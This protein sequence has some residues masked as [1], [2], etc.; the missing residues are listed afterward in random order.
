MQTQNIYESNMYDKQFEPK[1][2]TPVKQ[3]FKLEQKTIDEIQSMKPKFGFNGLGE[4]VFRRTYSRDNETWNDVVIRVIEGVMSIRKDH[5]CK[6]SLYWSDKEWQPFAREI[7]ISMFNMEWLPPGRGL[8]M[9][10]TDFAYKRGSMALNNCFS[11]DTQFWT[12]EGL[13]SFGDYKDG[14]KVTVRGKNKWMP[15]TIRSFGVQKLWELK[16]QCKGKTNTIFTTADHRWIVEDSIKTTKELENG[17]KLFTIEVNNKK[18]LWE[19]SSVTET[20]RTEEVWCVVE[21]EYEEFTLEGGIVTKNCAATETLYDLVHSAEWTMDAL[22]NGVGCGFDTSWRGSVSRPNKEDTELFVIDDSR[23]G[24]VHSLIK[25]MCAY[26]DS[27]K[28]GKNKFPKFDYSLIREAGKPIKGFGGLASGPAPLQKLHKRVESYLDSFCN[29][30]IENKDKTEKKPYNHTR[31]IADIFNAIGACVVAGNVRRCLPEGSRVHTN[32]GLVPIEEVK[33]GDNVCTMKGYKKV[34]NTFDQ[35]KQKLVKINTNTGHFRCTPNHRM[36]VHTKYFDYEWKCASELKSGDRLITSH[37]IIDGEKTQL[38]EQKNLTVPKLDKELAWFVGFWQNQGTNLPSSLVTTCCWGSKVKLCAQFKRFNV[39]I[40]C[41]KDYGGEAYNNNHTNDSY[42]VSCLDK[43]VVSYFNKHIKCRNVDKIPEYIMRGT[44]EVRQGYIFGITEN[45]CD[46]KFLN[47]NFVNDLQ[48]L[49]YSCGMST[50]VNMEGLL[51]K[52]TFMVDGIR[53]FTQN[54]YN[55]SEVVKVVD[56]ET[57]NTYD[58]EVEE[59]HEFFCNGY[60]TH[61]SAEIALGDV[62]DKTFINLKNYGLNPERG[63]IGWMSNNSVV[64]QPYDDYEDFSYIPEMAKRIHD[65]GEPGMIN[66]Y[67]MQKFGRYGKEMKDKANLVNPCVTDDTWVTTK[68]GA[69]QVKDLIGKKF[70]AMVDGKLYQCNKGFFSTGKKAVFK[71]VT[72]EGFE[73]RA[74]AN[75]KIMTADNEWV[76][77]KDLIEGDKVRV[78][79]HSVVSMIENNKE[80]SKGWLIGSLYGDGVVYHNREYASLSYKGETAQEM[81]QIAT[82]YLNEHKMDHVCGN[83]SKQYDQ[84]QLNSKG[85]FTL[86][87]Q[88]IS[89][90]R[91]LTN[92]IEKQDRA[93]IQGFLRGWFDTNSFIQEDKKNGVSIHIVCEKLDSIKKVQRIAL[94]LGIYS[95]VYKEEYPKKLIIPRFSIKTYDEMVGFCNPLMSQKLRKILS[96]Y[97]RPFYGTRYEATISSIKLDGVHEVYDATV[98]GIHAF[99]ANGIYVHNCGEIALEN[100]ELC[101][102]GD[103][104][105]LTKRGYFKI[106][107]CIDKHV[108]IWNGQKWSTVTPFKTASNQILYRVALTD[109]SYLDVTAQ[110]KWSVRN[111]ESKYEE[112][113]TA[114]LSMGMELEMTEL[115]AKNFENHGIQ[116]KD[117]YIIGYYIGC[118]NN[119]KT[120]ISKHFFAMDTE[121]TY[122][123]VAGWLDS[124]TQTEEGY[125]MLRQNCGQLRDMQLLL[126]RIGINHCFIKE[127]FNCYSLTIP[128][129]ECKKLASYCKKNILKQFSE[130]KVEPQYIKSIIMLDGKHDTFCFTEPIAH[131]GVFNNV[132]TH[133]C[134]LSET[135]PPRCNDKEVFY[136]ALKYATFYASTVS[137]LPTHRPETNAVIAKN[138]RIGVSISGVAQWASGC[139]PKDWGPMNYTKMTTFLRKGYKIVRTENTKLAEQAGVP[140]SIR[141]TT[142][143][144][145]GS[146]SLLAGVTPGIHYPVSRYAIRRMRIGKDSPLVQPLIDAGIKHEDDT[147]SDNTMVFEFVIDHGDVR[148]C[149]DVNPWEQFGLMAMLQRTYSDNCVSCTIY[150]D[151]E[152]E[153]PE[154]IE[155]MLAMYIPVLKSVS[156]LP[157]AGHGYAQAP[158]EPIDRE[159]YMRRRNEYKLP[160]F[161]KVKGNVP[162]GSKYCNGDKCIRLPSKKKRKRNDV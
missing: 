32:R 104:H 90:G 14:D 48:K 55:F 87:K 156:M 127:E 4:V 112:V 119:D 12:T 111:A 28:Y 144:P 102:S 141:V 59:E 78:H 11:V 80:F 115:S 117:A 27:P 89:R 83:E 155:E 151:K 123:F 58:I 121:S 30:Y 75:H 62:G 46:I 124:E 50:S 98:E 131:K 37:M 143:K 5:F 81:I 7:A 114:D 35:G 146:I 49:A 74:T 105:I 79:K 36:A 15:A 25:I 8:W 68:N 154:N 57:E 76:E 13:K 56:D 140:A 129:F 160:N 31:L 18:N 61:N 38:P 125:I 94:Q 137:L 84:I 54:N 159:T 10:G 19:V 109:G 9:M 39:P 63:E 24:W 29:G 34:L 113:K 157:H 33:V 142:I 3:R 106:S 103:T 132:L 126:R 6:Q 133:Q 158:Y 95:K 52:I 40:E 66:L 138:R 17:L 135:F 152:K 100:M 41:G 85:L 71:L 130:R 162:E 97:K 92:E 134:N 43:E 73:L 108:E 21:P 149:K 69:V 88:Y 2:I 65:N 101:V 1:S 26:I 150:F 91:N 23:E 145:S 147:Y 110:H 60:L 42:V 93:F 148:P 86:A 153:T 136:K 70:E 51:Y 77:L 128:S 116:R 53:N 107:D 44:H 22:M 139:V 118:N 161:R 122:N 82:T 72:K 20:K 120:E 47:E 45:G 16:V 67:N 99:D 64:L 96:S